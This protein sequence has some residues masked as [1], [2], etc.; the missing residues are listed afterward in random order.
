[1]SSAGYAIQ[2]VFIV[3]DVKSQTHPVKGNIKSPVVAACPKGNWT[4]PPSP[5]T[6]SPLLAV[7]WDALF[8]AALRA[9]AE[10]GALCGVPCTA[11]RAAASRVPWAGPPPSPL[12]LHKEESGAKSRLC[13]LWGTNERQLFFPPFEILFV[14][15]WKEWRLSEEFTENTW[16]FHIFPTKMIVFFLLLP[17]GINNS[18]IYF[19]GLCSVNTC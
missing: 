17:D 14:L 2:L 6:L 13:S 16:Y 19:R 15:I 3:C 1:M 9:W 7:L 12:R 10:Q 11:V 18:L 4:T 5:G 8:R